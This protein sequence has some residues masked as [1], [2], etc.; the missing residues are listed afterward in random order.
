MKKRM[1]SLV[2]TVAIMVS[3]CAAFMPE[4]KALPDNVFRPLDKNAN[5]N[6]IW[7][8]STEGYL[9]IIREDEDKD[10]YW[11]DNW[12]PRGAPW[13][14]YRDGIK[15]V[16]LGA[17]ITSIGNYAFNDCTSLVAINQFISSSSSSEYGITLIGNN[18]FYGCVSLTEVNFQALPGNGISHIGDDAFSGC[19]N[20][21]SLQTNEATYVGKRAFDGCVNLLALNLENVLEINDF[22]FRGCVRLAAIDLPGI[23][24]YI[25]EGIFTGCRSVSEITVTDEGQGNLYLDVARSQAGEPGVLFCA[26]PELN[27]EANTLEWGARVLKAEAGLPGDYV[28]L[29]GYV[30]DFSRF[31]P[32]NGNESFYLTMID[33]EAFAYQ[34]NLTTV[35]IPSTVK[36][37][38][39]NAFS[40]CNNLKDAYFRGHA[41]IVPQIPNVAQ[42]ARI[43][44]NVADG[45]L[46]Y[47][48]FYPTISSTGWPTPPSTNWRGYKAIANSSFVLIEPATPQNP[49]TPVVTTIE[50][51]SSVQLRSTVYPLSSSQAVTWSV[52]WQSRDDGVNVAT[53]SSNGVV[54]A[55]S[56]GEAIIRVTTVDG[57]RSAERRVHVLEQI[58]PMTAVATDKTQMI[59]V[60][61]DEP[62]SLTAIVHPSNVA[63]FP[64]LTWR[65]SD[66]RIAYVTVDNPAEP[67]KARVVAVSPGTVTVT[68]T[69]VTARG[70]ITS[71][72]VTVTVVRDPLDPAMFV[73]V[74]NVTLE[75]TIPSVPMGGTLNLD[76]IYTVYPA[77]AT[78]NIIE[79]WRYIEDLS[80]V[81][82]I[83]AGPNGE[84]DGGI[85]FVP[86]LQT[87]TVVVEAVIIKGRSDETWG[88]SGDV[89]DIDY[90]Q[91]FTIN[92]T[93]F[94][95][96]VA[97][98]DV[99]GI[100]HVGIPLRLRGT[101]MPT[102]RPIEWEIK[103]AG[104]TG[105]YI[106]PVSGR[107]I[108]Q[109][110]GRVVVTAT[111]RNGVWMQFQGLESGR[112][113][114]FQ[115]DFTITVVPYNPNPLTVRSDPGGRIG[116]DGS[117]LVSG[118]IIVG[119]AGEEVIELTAAADSGYEF[120]G[121]YTSNGGTFADANSATTEFTMPGVATTVTAFFSYVGITGGWTGG[122]VVLPTPGHYFTNGSRYTEGSAMAFAHVT[123]RDF[124]LFS[125]VELDNRTLTK[126]G[127][128]TAE[129]M[130]GYTMV[131]LANGYLDTLAQGSHTLIV[132]F[133]DKVSVTAA[134]TVV[135]TGGGSAGQPSSGSQLYDDVRTSDSSYSDI[136]F[137][138]ERGWMTSSASDPRLFR[139]NAAATQAE[140]VEALYRLSGSPSVTSVQGRRLGGREGA[141][142]WANQ[143]SI[144]PIGGKISAD[145]PT[146]RQDLAHFLSRLARLH[147][148]T[149]P[150][151]RGAPNFTDEWSISSSARSAVTS[152]Y[153]AGIMD[154]RTATTFVPQGNVTRAELATILTRFSTVMK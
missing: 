68:V 3:L 133:S 147:N 105:A 139:P 143:N 103:D 45:F 15:I 120:A 140:V 73:P 87:G 21:I 65:S 93:P 56:P 20:L 113:G 36:S 77:N 144:A 141:I 97:I 131:T 146:T 32:S 13:Y 121:W 64:E 74:T 7:R 46:I 42:N 137:V 81:K 26:Y 153:R 109:R 30:I 112:L 118:E 53:V 83:P 123:Y 8:L 101:V 9:Q 129:R 14:D 94:A 5:T 23:M 106:D 33:V 90:V 125:Y 12:G 44:E 138:S 108:A 84:L 35:T 54:H 117:Q 110:I 78:N 62:E 22:A 69:A 18:A 47:F 92:V 151:V 31:P 17:G 52:I 111:V 124:Q 58:I 40:W 61:D 41:P 142:E 79:I 70:T 2:V 80:T 130:G 104:D 96:V 55:V 132:Y 27:L 91:R 116:V 25:G 49:Y 99:P 59:L 152:L 154:G 37:I 60:L 122:I 67:H 98:K 66:T 95:P 149:Y 86:W 85:L 63:P 29:G 135:R 24:E 48:D 134:F 39:L 145:S 150:V 128:Y 71:A 38:G 6:I 43:F 50:Q 89:A 88:Y 136:A 82:G 16:S 4:A 75:P 51:G 1:I 11:P 28:I 119:K 127:H 126:D 100:A 57:S 10:A 148:L 76:E 34:S 115:E 19:V 107:F 114:P 102:D 72:P